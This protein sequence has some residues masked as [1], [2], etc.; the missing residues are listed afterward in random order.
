MAKKQ[1]VK[2]KLMQASADHV[3][4]RCDEEELT[5][6]SNRVNESDGYMFEGSVF[7]SARFTP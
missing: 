1:E 4:C 2:G 6:G 5:K 7:N 3:R